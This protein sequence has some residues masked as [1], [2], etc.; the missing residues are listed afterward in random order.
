MPRVIPNQKE[1]FDKD[2][3]FKKLTQESEVKYSAMREL[4]HDER[5]KKFLEFIKEG[6]S[7]ISF[8]NTGMTCW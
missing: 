7:S 8:L 2:E 5:K 3:L 1:R 4:Q 6:H